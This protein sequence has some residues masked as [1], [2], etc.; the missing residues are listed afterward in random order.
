MWPSPV[1][2]RASLFLMSVCCGAV[3]AGCV[4]QRADDIYRQRQDRLSQFRA[5]SRQDIPEAKSLTG[6]DIFFVE[7]GRTWFNGKA[8]CNGCHGRDAYP[9]QVKN[10]DVAELNPAPTELRVPLG[11]SVRELFFTIKYGMAGTGM[12]PVQEDTGLSDEDLYAILAYVLALQGQ[13]TT[14]KDLLSRLGER[15]AG[16]DQFIY[17][18]CATDENLSNKARERCE[19]PYRRR[20]RTLVTGRPADI[21]V[22]R[23]T[24]IQSRCSTMSDLTQQNQCYRDHIALTRADRASVATQPIPTAAAQS[25]VV[26]T[27]P[28][29]VQETIKKKC[30]VQ[31]P[32]DFQMQTYCIEKQQ[33]GLQSLSGEA[34]MERLSESHKASIQSKC[35]KEW[36]ED[37]QMR[38]YCEQQQVKGV[39]ALAK[40]RPSDI[41]EVDYNTAIAHCL[42]QWP[43]DNKVRAYCVEKQTEAV[44]KLRSR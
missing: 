32:D 35:A 21:V 40:P 20:F 16:A 44:R 25:V 13:P 36:P 11:K 42:K 31:W 10:A 18:L 5:E 39:E 28:D 2:T 17:R 15:G 7:R 8:V 22:S 4:A 1:V 30:A 29:E 26:P 43:D 41:A 6:A 3:L 38:A 27:K 37:F 12:V 9:N 23:Y 24:E 19:E 14:I 33:K 34:S